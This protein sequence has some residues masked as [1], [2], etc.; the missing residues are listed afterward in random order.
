MRN[1]T[2]LWFAVKKG[3][4]AMFLYDA[5]PIWAGSLGKEEFAN[6]PLKSSDWEKRVSLFLCCDLLILLG[7]SAFNEAVEEVKSTFLIS[8]SAVRFM[9]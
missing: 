9:Q 7:S 6:I 2:W 1:E 8:D 3:T 5:N 4:Y